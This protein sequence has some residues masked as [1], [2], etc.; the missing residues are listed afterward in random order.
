MYI[1]YSLCIVLNF[2]KSQ[3]LY[4]TALKISSKY[5]LQKGNDIPQAIDESL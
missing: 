2:G 4:S 5:S 3:S 1:R